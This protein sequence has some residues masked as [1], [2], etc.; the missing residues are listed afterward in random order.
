M[1][2]LTIPETQLIEWVQHLSPANKRTVL[3]ALIPALDDY[4]V[5]VT[6]GS[7]RARAAAAQRG[8]DWETLTNPQREEL[9]DA[10]L[11]EA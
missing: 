3:R 4:E 8:L 11:H 7:E 5:L 10:I 6:Y 9:I 2:T 1:L